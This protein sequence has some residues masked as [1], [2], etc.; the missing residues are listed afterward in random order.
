MRKIITYILFAALLILVS[1]EVKF[2]TH[3]TIT[4]LPAPGPFDQT[5]VVFIG[6]SL[7]AGFQSAGLVKDFQGNS[8]PNQI[9]KQMGK[10]SFQ[11]PL[12]DDPGISSTPGVGV[13]DF[14]P[15]T[16]AISP[17]GTYTDPIALLLNSTLSSPYDNLGIPGATVLDVNST[18]SSANSISPGNSFFDLVLRNPNFGDMTQVDQAVTLNPNLVVLWI[19]SNDALGAT[20]AGGDTTIVTPLTAFQAAYQAAIDRLKTIRGGNLDIIVANIPNVTDIP[21]V[22]ILD[23]VRQ[24]IPLLGITSPVPVLF[25]SQPNALGGIDFVPIDFGGFYLPLYTEEFASGVTHVLLPALSEYQSSGLGVPDSAIIASTLITL[26]GWDTLTA[27]ATAQQLVLGMMS[28]GLTP[29]G[30][31]VPGNLTI[32]VA[33]ETAIEAAVTGFNQIISSIAAMEGIPIADANQLL[34][35]VNTNGIDGFSGKFVLSD[36]LSTAFSLDGVHPDNAGYAIVANEFIKAINQALNLSGSN[37][38][39]LIDTD[40]FRGQ[41]VGTSIGKLSR[42][43]ANLVKPLFVN[44]R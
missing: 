23:A 33:E 15:S 26:A 30:I 3:A 13:L 10:T 8:F 27:S 32:T 40:Q 42:E 41:Y 5:V 11:Q 34:S 4:V 39:A 28:A 2:P 6:S 19:G 25:Q 29:S 22:N 1:C 38:I 14:N 43:A 44:R 21:Y 20:L 24:P 17:R 12:I 35:D 16:G 18:T 37:Q 9:A 7:T 36:P 31:P